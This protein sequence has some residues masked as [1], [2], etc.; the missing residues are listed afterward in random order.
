MEQ[1]GTNVAN[2]LCSNNKDVPRA[3]GESALYELSG[4]LWGDAAAPVEAIK[5]SSKPLQSQATKNYST[6]VEFDH[7][8]TQTFKFVCSYARCSLPWGKTGIETIM[9]PGGPRDC[10]RP[11]TVSTSQFIGT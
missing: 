9:D 6:G 2:S 3:A 5:I 1:I 8:A 11:N 10:Y 4:H 7:T